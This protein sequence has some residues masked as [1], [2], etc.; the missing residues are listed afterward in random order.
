MKLMLAL[1]VMLG[2]GS[3]AFVTTGVA[4]VGCP[5]CADAPATT[6]VSTPVAA[7]A[8]KESCDAC[9]LSGRTEQVL[10][11]PDCAGCDQETEMVSAEAE[12]EAQ[13]VLTA[14]GEAI[15]A[16]GVAGKPVW[17][18]EAGYGFV[19]GEKTQCPIT[20]ATAAT[21]TMAMAGAEAGCEMCELVLT[22]APVEESGEADAMTCPEGC[23]K[24]CCVAQAE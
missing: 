11:K 12:E 23:T 8:E 5:S 15:H 24:A 20:V 22:T 2:L 3:A 7:D 21:H 6:P 19:N 1:F 4:G 17:I 18:K 9:P 10:D 13:I 14:H 16:L